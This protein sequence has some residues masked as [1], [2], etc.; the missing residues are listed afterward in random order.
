VNLIDYKKHFIDRLKP[1]YEPEEAG[2]FFDLLAEE[3][4]KMSRLQIA[5]NPKTELAENQHKKFE[6]ALF[7]LLEHEPI[8]YIVGKTSFY[9]LEFKVNPNV[10][11]PRPET[12]ELVKWI[13]NDF[14]TSHLMPHTLSL[15]ILDIGTGSGCIAVSLAKN[16]P[17]AKITALDISEKALEVAKENAKLN[18]V[19]IDFLS[20]NI[21]EMQNL[22]QKFDLIVSN[23]PYVRESEKTQ[24]QR[25]VLEHEPKTALYV[26]DSDPLLFYRKIANLAKAS[27]NKEG[28][29]YLE[30]N[31]YLR[32]ETENLFSKNG[33]STELREDIFGNIRML[34]AW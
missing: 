18:Q 8:Q 28:K 13:L 29:V 19:K 16:L 3:Y 34:K 20:G 15:K 4:L 11:I 10:L 5:L 14:S 25:N 2:S 31:Q 22:P 6:K 24:M 21:L 23:P 27:L 30:I 26:K 9:G 33:F 7:R 12:E 1:E 32:K 17:Q